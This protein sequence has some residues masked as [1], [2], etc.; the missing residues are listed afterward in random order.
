MDLW[1]LSALSCWTGFIPSNH[2]TIPVP[3]AIFYD[4]GNGKS[5]RVVLFPSS[6]IWFINTPEN[7]TFAHLL[8]LGPPPFRLGEGPLAFF[9][10][11]FPDVK[12]AMGDVRVVDAA[13]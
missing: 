3:Q 1:G 7:R 4:G 10:L 11:P 9:H 2:P 12:D 13:G 5:E 8:P 6:T